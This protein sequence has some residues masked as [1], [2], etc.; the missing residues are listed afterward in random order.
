[1]SW[2]YIPH[3]YRWIYIYIQRNFS[4]TKKILPTKK[5]LSCIGSD[6]QTSIYDKHDD[7]NSSGWVVMLLDSHGT[8]FTFRGWFDLLG[9]VPAVWIS[10]LKIFKSLRNYWHSVTYVTSFD[11]HLEVLRSG[12]FSY[13]LKPH[14]RIYFWRNPSPGLLRLSSLETNDGQMRSVFRLVGLENTRVIQKVLLLTVHH[15]Q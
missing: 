3:R 5:L 11:K 4:W 8:V 1:M 13:S 10:I 9:I 15:A 7:I 14:S 2:R 6:V 12:L